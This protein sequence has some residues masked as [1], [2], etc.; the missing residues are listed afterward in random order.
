MLCLYCYKVWSTSLCGFL[1]HKLSSTLDYGSGH[2]FS[3]MSFLFHRTSL[4][5][6][7]SK[8]SC[9]LQ[10][11]RPRLLLKSC[12]SAVMWLW[13]RPFPLLCWINIPT[14]Q[15]TQKHTRNII[16]LYNWKDPVMISGMAG[17]ECSNI[18]RT[19]PLPVS[20]C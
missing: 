12:H 2:L 16:G 15:Q 8:I 4:L 5:Y 14:P 3:F 20:Q 19:L 7:K 1:S 10:V 9:E 13:V 17:T 11:Q 6:C 18:F